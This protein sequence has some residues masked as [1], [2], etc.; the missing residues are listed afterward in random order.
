[1]LL[2]FKRVKQVRR[3]YMCEPE[4]DPF[5]KRV[6]RVNPNMTRT[7]LAS[8]HDLFIN[9]LVV[10]GSRVVSDFATP[11]NNDSSFGRLTLHLV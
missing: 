10:S 3:V 11:S 7:H 8:T 4:H 6:S 5:I 9:G 2:L 1:M